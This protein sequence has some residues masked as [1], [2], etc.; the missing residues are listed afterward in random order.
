MLAYAGKAHHD[1]LLISLALGSFPSADRHTRSAL[2]YYPLGYERLPYFAHDY[3]I[4]LTTFGCDAEAL[5]LL[6]AVM[7]VVT[8]PAERLVVLGTVARASAGVGDRVRFLAAVEDVQVLA[9]LYECNAAGA[10]ALASEGALAAGEWERAAELAL[11]A[12]EVATRRHEREP[13]RRA[14]LVLEAVE[15]RTLPPQPPQADPLR[16]AET[17]ALLLEHLADLGGERQRTTD[18]GARSR[19]RAELTKFS[20]TG[21]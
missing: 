5:K 18:A 9:G 19:G 15:S 12:R 8:E 10:L 21:R 4:V 6:D 20:I 3:A 17:T 16:V 2:N 1:M 7:R 11:A 13:D 14:A